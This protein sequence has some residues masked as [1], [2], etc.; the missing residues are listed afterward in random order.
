[1]ETANALHEALTNAFAGFKELS[2]S[3]ISSFESYLNKT[4]TNRTRST[5]EP[6]LEYIADVLRRLSALIVDAPTLQAGALWN[7]FSV[8]PGLR[9]PLG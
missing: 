4:F 3:F 9:N 1:M 2:E 7:V 6:Y 8:I 5:G